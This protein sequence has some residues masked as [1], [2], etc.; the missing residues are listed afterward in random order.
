MREEF[1][2]FCTDME[3]LRAA[4]TS[5]ATPAATALPRIIAR[6]VRDLGILSP[7]QAIHRMTAVAANELRLYDRGRIAP[8]AAADLVI[9]DLNRTRDQSTFAHPNLPRPKA[10]TTSSSTASPSSNPANPPPPAPA[11]SSAVE[12][13]GS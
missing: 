11:A 5:W 7:E 8:A 3:T 13:R 2:S 6:Y 4:P 9:F 1:V 10:S 12:G